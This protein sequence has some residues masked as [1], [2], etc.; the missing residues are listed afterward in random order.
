MV[1]IANSFLRDRLRFATRQC[2]GR[3]KR[4][5]LPERQIFSKKK[6]S[7]LLRSLGAHAQSHDSW[8]SRPIIHLQFQV[9]NNLW[10]TENIFECLWGHKTVFPRLITRDFFRRINFLERNSLRCY[11]RQNLDDKTMT[12]FKLWRLKNKLYYQSYQFYDIYTRPIR[13]TSRKARTARV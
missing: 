10:E 12:A 3:C 9:P 11:G 2:E 5:L 6:V 4:F 8:M 13:R 7:I 1:E